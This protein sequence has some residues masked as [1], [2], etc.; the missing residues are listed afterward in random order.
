M[1]RHQASA[2]APVSIHT[3]GKSCSDI[4]RLLA[5]NDPPTSVKGAAAAG[6]W[7]RT[8]ARA[9]MGACW[10]R[11]AGRMVLSVRG[12]SVC[13]WANGREEDVVGRLVGATGLWGAAPQREERAAGN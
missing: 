1:R 11:A 3:R 4:G 9:S 10:R 8:A 7:R 13:D 2:L 6:D 12:A 5:I